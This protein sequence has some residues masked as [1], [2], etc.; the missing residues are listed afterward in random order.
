MDH[1]RRRKNIAQMTSDRKLTV[2]PVCRQT[3]YPHRAHHG[4]NGQFRCI[5]LEHYNRV[6]EIKRRESIRVVAICV[7]APPRIPDHGAKRI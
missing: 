1:K 4:S 3:R 2:L 7:K 5:D 6:L